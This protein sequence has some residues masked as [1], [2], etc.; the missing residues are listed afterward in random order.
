MQNSNILELLI[1]TS[2]IYKEK[3]LNK[4][5]LFIYGNVNSPLHFEAIFLKNNFLHLTGVKYKKGSN[6][7]FDKLISNRMKESEIQKRKDGTTDLKI[8]ALPL[9]N[10]IFKST[11]IIGD[12]DSTKFKLY[13][14][15]LAGGVN[16]CIGFIKKNNY[17]IPNTLLSEDIRTITNVPRYRVLAIFRKNKNE[18]TYNE[19]CYLAKGIKLSEIKITKPCKDLISDSLL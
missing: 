18:K 9:L 14:D 5:I 2:R 16:A 6:N 8:N 12:Y 13:T 10:N 15:K 7:F 17:Y 11:K 4:N 19:L 3:L 1:N